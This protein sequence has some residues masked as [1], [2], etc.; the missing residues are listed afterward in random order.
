MSGYQPNL[1]SA[2]QAIIGVVRAPGLGRL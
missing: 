1:S 2:P